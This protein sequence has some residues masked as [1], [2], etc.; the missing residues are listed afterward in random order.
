MLQKQLLNANGTIFLKKKKKPL[1]LFII[2]IRHYRY[3]LEAAY[4]LRVERARQQ[5]D[6]I[7]AKEQF[8]RY[9]HG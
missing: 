6:S 3:F 4:F 7:Y 8:Y 2:V 1:F 9:Y 5:S